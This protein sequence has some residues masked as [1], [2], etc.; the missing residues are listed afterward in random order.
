MKMKLYL[1]NQNF[2]CLIA[3]GRETVLSKY[4]N[5][6]RKMVNCKPLWLINE[7]ASRHK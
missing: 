1:V 4:F 7:Y 2:L 3:V 5:E 6:P